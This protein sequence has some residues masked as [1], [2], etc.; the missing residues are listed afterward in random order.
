MQNK[1]PASVNTGSSQS[2]C[3]LHYLQAGGSVTELE[4]L[5]LFYCVSV[6]QRIHDL[7]RRGHVIISTAEKTPSGK[8]IARYSLKTSEGSQ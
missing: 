7:R 5:R 8:L 4:G 6:A 2:A 3:I 1:M